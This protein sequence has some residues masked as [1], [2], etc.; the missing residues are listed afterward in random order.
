MITTRITATLIAT[1]TALK[2]LERRIPKHRSPD[3]A[4]TIT[5][6]ARLW[7]SPNIH[8]GGFACH[9]AEV[10]TTF[11]YWDQPDATVAAPSASSRIK[12][13]PM[14]QATSSPR[15]AYENV[16]AEPATGTTDANSA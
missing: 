13:Q 3:S 1:I 11:K 14:I 2:P 10:T 5:A 7:W 8:A 16:Y 9:G 15:L 12:S 6:A 4:S